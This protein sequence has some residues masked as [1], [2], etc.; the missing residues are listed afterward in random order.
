MKTLTID[1][2]AFAQ[3]TAPRTT[4]RSKIWT[5][6]VLA[7]LPLSFLTWDGVMKFTTMPEV[8]EGSARLG[9]S[10][11]ILPVLGTLELL[12]VVLTLFRRTRVLG[13]VLLTAYLGGAV[14]THIRLGD[15]LFTHTLFP[16]YFAALI[17][18]GF[19]L[20]DERVRAASPF[21]RG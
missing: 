21:G 18:G 12:G 20:I 2:V 14:E 5:G 6:R 19:C 13:A 11:G 7:G 17:W 3:A 15:P 16:I 4:G 1:E 9:F 8:I 10:R